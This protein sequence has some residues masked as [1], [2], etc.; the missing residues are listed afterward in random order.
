[1]GMRIFDTDPDAKRERTT[2][3]AEEFDGKLSGGKQEKG[4][5]VALTEWRFVLPKQETADA[6]AQLYGGKP[7]E[8]ETDSDYFIELL[9][10]AKE[11]SVILAGPKA[12]Q[13]D[14]KLFNQAQKL[15]HHCDGVD[16]I[17]H[18][19]DDKVG[20]PC[21]CPESLSERKALARDFMGPKPAIAVTFS[22]ADDP[23][24]GT[25]RYQTGSWSLAETLWEAEEDLAAIGGE[26]LATLSLEP[27]EYVA[28][29]GPM[30]GKTVSYTKPVLRVHKAY[31][32]AIAD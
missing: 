13:S 15:I 32:D 7:V 14:M 11:L 21:G 17:S 25:F 12:V 29:G 8:L 23:E 1:M 3:Y 18:A 31:A 22:L 2:S 30:K 9:T 4:K 24:L 5:P 6:L 20:T 28:K 27:V 16:Y 19:D 26:A 10:N